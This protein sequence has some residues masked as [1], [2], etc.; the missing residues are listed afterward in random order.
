MFGNSRQ[1]R[2]GKHQSN[3]DRLRSATMN[4]VVPAQSAW[5]PI[6]GA[7]RFGEKKN[8]SNVAQGR[9]WTSR[10]MSMGSTDCPALACSIKRSSLRF[11]R[12]HSNLYFPFVVFSFQS[13][14]AHIPLQ[15]GQSLGIRPLI[16]SMNGSPS[17]LHATISH[18]LE[19]CAGGQNAQGQNRNDW[20][21]FHKSPPFCFFAEAPA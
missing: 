9:I 13:T 2:R 17:V 3:Y 20:Y 10:S 4:E 5:T 14:S 8:V 11:Q 21:L 1:I 19:D 15:S 12:S 18:R 16:L 7:S 6:G